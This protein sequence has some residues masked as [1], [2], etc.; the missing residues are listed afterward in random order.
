M[1]LPK[2]PETH[3]I[4]AESWR[5]LQALAPKEWIVREVS[6][7]DYGIDAYI[8]LAS[9][10][11]H[12]TGD[13]MSVQLKGIEQGIKWKERKGSRSA[14]SPQIKSSTANYWL[15]LPVPVFL[16]VADLTAQDIYY[17]PAQEGLR[18][19]FGNL[20][21]QDGITF[22]LHDELRLTSK[23]GKALLPW[24]YGRERTHEQ[25]SFHVMNLLSHVDLFRDFI[26]SHQNR[27]SFMEVEEDA[28]LQF[29][30]LYECCHMASLYLEGDWKMEP[31]SK[32]YKKDRAEWK[33]DSVWLHEQT[34]DYALQKL[35]TLFP[36]LVRKAIERVTE[37]QAAYWLDK[38]PLFFNLC[39]GLEWTL[40]R[41]E[42]EDARHR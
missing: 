15:R 13:L 36:R 25:F 1:K 9:K 32:L 26:S 29:R 21:K 28:H 27:D 41:L 39:H 40:R 24:F 16:F 20:D 2:R 30:A 33:D 6:E 11:G 42:Q 5:L 23:V 10:D 17:V 8:E 37:T 7:R 31:L 18:A 35:E 19:Q 4:E 12:I 3:V 34:L 14:R 22:S 38:D